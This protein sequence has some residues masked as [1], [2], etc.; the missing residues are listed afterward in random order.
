MIQQDI[1]HLL[2]NS[3]I[4]N[5]WGAMKLVAHLKLKNDTLS[6]TLIC[7]KKNIIQI[8]NQNYV[9]KNNIP[10]NSYYLAKI[11]KLLAICFNNGFKPIK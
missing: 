6:Y 3:Q 7:I 9:F 2:S 5:K 8:T 1:F 11:L 10:F 4:N